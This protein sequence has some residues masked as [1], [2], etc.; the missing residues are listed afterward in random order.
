MAQEPKF[1]SATHCSRFD[2]NLSRQFTV[3][4]GVKLSTGHISLF[5]VPVATEKIE[6]RRKPRIS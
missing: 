1:E 2:D 3:P 6:L 4:C 5:E